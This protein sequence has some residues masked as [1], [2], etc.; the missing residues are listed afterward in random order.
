MR[1]MI[2]NVTQI[3]TGLL[4]MTSCG[5]AV[6]NNLLTNALTNTITGATTPTTEATA[7]TTETALTTSTT[8]DLLTDGLSG[9]FKNLLGTKSLSASSVKGTWTYES[10][11]VVFESSNLLQQAGGTLITNKLENKM[12]KYLDKAGF[13]AGKVTITFDGNNAYSMTVGNNV[14]EG[15]YTVEGSN[16]TLTR[17]SLLSHPMTANLSLQINA[18]QITFQADKLLDFVTKMSSL[19][20]NTSLSLIGTMVKGYDGMQLGLQF[21]KQ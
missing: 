20:A 16:I 8:S 1:K 12:Q 18:M 19:T 7:P 15:T 6:A 3:C 2:L 9:L 5:S 13:V 14:I 21:R 10:P 4:L 11:A 17:N